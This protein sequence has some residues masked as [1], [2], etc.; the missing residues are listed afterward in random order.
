MSRLGPSTRRETTRLC[1]RR[2]IRSLGDKGA[3]AADRPAFRYERCGGFAWIA[4]SE[5]PRLQALRAVERRGRDSNPRHAL[6]TC[7]G[8]SR[9][10]VLRS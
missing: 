7:N 3:F 4:L 1:D 6:T 10:A 2:A 5:V 8:F 9:P